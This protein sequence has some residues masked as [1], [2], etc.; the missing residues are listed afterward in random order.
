MTKNIPPIPFTVIRRKGQKHI[1]I[2]VHHD[3]RVTVSAPAHASDERVSEAVNIKEKWIRNHVERVREKIS[4]VDEL[5]EIPLGGVPHQVSI[6]YDPTRRGHIRLDETNRRI[7]MRTG[8]K[9][10][11]SRIE[12]V[13]RFLKRYCI[14]AIA[15]EVH[16]LSRPM[17]I[18]VRRIFFRNQKT[19]WGSSSAK[20]NISLN[21]RVAL[22]PAEV[23][24]Y[25]IMHELIHQ[26]HMNHS[27]RF[28]K[29]VAK[30]CPK[31]RKSDQWLK[32]HSFYLGLFR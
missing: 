32:E 26:I 17:R 1:N 15:P 28:W 9:S 14:D 13:V 27:D 8:T 16:S 2:R 11:E 23:R 21:F 12:A 7:L 20:G 22:L 30:V 31:Y 19:R 29:Q 4:L 5:S 6:E 10:R 3:G 18:E 24:T 25:L